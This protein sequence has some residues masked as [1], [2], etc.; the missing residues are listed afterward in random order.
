[1]DRNSPASALQAL[2]AAADREEVQPTNPI[3]LG[4]VFFTEALRRGGIPASHAPF[5]QNAALGAVHPLYLA[6]N[7]VREFPEKAGA[8]MNQFSDLMTWLSSLSAFGGPRK[9]Y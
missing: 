2:L 7:Q 4:H 8:T 5:E 1:M 6:G 3:G 9:A